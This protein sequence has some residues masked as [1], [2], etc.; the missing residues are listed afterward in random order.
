MTIWVI[1]RNPEEKPPLTGKKLEQDQ[2][3]L[4]SDPHFS[5][6]YRWNESHLSR[7]PAVLW[8]WRGK[9]AVMVK[10]VTFF[11]SAEGIFRVILVCLS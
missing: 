1:S 8:K 11:T 3:S 5:T 2:V 4:I 6:L 10:K 7:E 9:I